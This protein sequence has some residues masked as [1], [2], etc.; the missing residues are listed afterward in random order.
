MVERNLP[1]DSELSCQGLACGLGSLHGCLVDV[2]RI[3][4]NRLFIFRVVNFTP[5]FLRFFVCLFE[6]DRDW[7]RPQVRWRGRGRGRSRLFTEQGAHCRTPSQDSKVM[8]WAEGRRSTDWD[9]QVP[10]Y[11]LLCVIYHCFQFYSSVNFSG[12]YR[13]SSSSMSVCPVFHRPAPW[14][15]CGE[16][17]TNMPCQACSCQ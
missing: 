4:N 2:S 5:F 3:M 11:L 6:R 1:I 12:R 15:C 17:A 16:E 8:T 7:G 9:T 13:T 14:G 10:L